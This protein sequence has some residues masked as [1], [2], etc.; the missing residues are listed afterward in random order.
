VSVVW[1]LRVSAGEG[2][3]VDCRALTAW[4]TPHPINTTKSS[5]FT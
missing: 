4:Q 2:L 5:H 1:S 3:T